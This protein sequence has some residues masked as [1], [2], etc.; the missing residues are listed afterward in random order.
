MRRTLFLLAAAAIAAIAASSAVGST[1]VSVTIRHQAH[2]CHT[3]A[4][5]GHAFASSQSVKV[6]RGTAMIFTNDDVMPHTLIQLAGPKVALQAPKM[7][8]TG[9]HATIVLKTPGVYRFGTKAGEDYKGVTL[10][11]TG[12][13]NVLTL[14]VVVR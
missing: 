2:G 10:K 7:G 14:K 1:A 4:A 9:A 11:T 13:D 8:H 12:E 5:A 3:W 6:T